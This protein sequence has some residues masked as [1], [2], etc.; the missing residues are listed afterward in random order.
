MRFFP[1]NSLCAAAVCLFASATIAW[2]QSAYF[3]EVSD[4]TGI[5][6]QSQIYTI[7]DTVSSQLAPLISGSLRFAEWRLNGSPMREANGSAAHQFSFSLDS[8]STAVAHYLETSLDSDADTLPDW[9]EMRH[10]GNLGLSGDDDPDAD[11][12]SLLAEYQLGYLPQVADDPRHGGISSVA[13]N[14]LAY[15]DSSASY[16]VTFESSPAD[17]VTTVE[18]IVLPGEAV[19][20]PT[21]PLQQN[22]YRFTGWLMQAAG[23]M[24]EGIR[25]ADSTGRSLF[26]LE[27]TPS[28]STTVQA[29]YVLE[30]LDSDS[31]GLPDWWELQYGGGLG[32]T[33]DMDA[34][35]DGFTLSEEYQLGYH[36]LVA[37]TVN[38]GGLSH[39]GSAILSYSDPVQSISVSFSSNPE[40]LIKGQTSSLVAGDTVSAPSA[41]TVV[42]NYRFV[43][44]YQDGTRQVDATGRALFDLEL[45]PGASA[46]YVARYLDQGEDSDADDLPDWWELHYLGVL[47]YS[48]TD[49]LDAD[50]LDLAQEYQSG[51]NPLVADQVRHGGVSGTGSQTL[52]VNLAPY[53]LNI[54]SVS[55]NNPSYGS[56][57]GAGSYQNSETVTVSATAAQGYVFRNWSGDVPE[58]FETAASFSFT[59]S[60]S[61]NLTAQFAPLWELNVSASHAERGSVSGEGNYI[62]GTEVTVTASA[63]PG[64]VFDQ[65]S[66]D[67]SANTNPLVVI[68]SQHFSLTAKFIPDL[69]DPDEDGLTTYEE[70]MTYGSNPN[71]YDTSGDGLGDGDVVAAGFDPNT[72]FSALIDLISPQ[73]IEGRLGS[74][75]IEIS[76]GQANLRLQIERSED[77]STWT[78]HENDLIN[79]PMSMDGGK[80]FFRISI[81]E[82]FEDEPGST[83]IEISNGQ[84]NLRL[85]VERSEDMSTWTK[86]ENDVISIPMTMDEDKQYFRFSIPQE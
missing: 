86:H 43:A 4:P 80:Q 54:V 22:G 11:S 81:P 31:D 17:L 45:S 3:Y 83:L 65:W 55:A 84:A 64:Y 42:N 12:L 41:P 6:D 49:D 57:T 68:M 63:V 13:S 66:G 82:L 74:T 14:S 20:S 37:E 40:G 24:T 19:T 53:R 36:P 71:L 59:S 48:A 35:G 51:Y 62:D 75:Q 28:S 32:A 7:G 5:I 10:I 26:D 58:G 1:F 76:N 85:Q 50:G 23:W 46:D 34:D 33:G 8:E 9:W 67:A 25:Q 47:T 30:T 16:K 56:V 60:G 44:W 61:V 27:F 77:M 78:K 79:I 15:F 70:L 21:I 39:V 2:S 18:S 38:S 69:S 72:D 52:T 73:T 29:K